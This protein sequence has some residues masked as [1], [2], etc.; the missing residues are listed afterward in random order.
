MKFSKLREKKKKKR[1][2][3]KTCLLETTLP[4][5]SNIEFCIYEVKIQFLTP[6]KKE[7]KKKKE[8][9]KRKE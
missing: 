1:K 7:E 6:K 5:L 9:R 8:K 4:N 2:R 3:K